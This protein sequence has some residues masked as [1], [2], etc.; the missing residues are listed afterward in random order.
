MPQV[1]LVIPNGVG[2]LLLLVSDFA[3]AVIGDIIPG[4]KALEV[5]VIGF[6]FAEF[7]AMEVG[8]GAVP[9]SVDLH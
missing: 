2:G 7:S 5:F 8:N 9:E 1:K 4:H 3:Q 6:G